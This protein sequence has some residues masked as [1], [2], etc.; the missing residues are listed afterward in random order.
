MNKTNLDIFNMYKSALPVL[1]D[2]IENGEK[3]YTGLCSIVRDRCRMKN[4]PLKDAIR[5]WPKSSNYVV[6]PVPSNT[7][8]SAEHRYD[9]F[10]LSGRSMTDPDSPYGLARL[11]L[12]KHLHKEFTEKMEWYHTQHILEHYTEENLQEIREAM[13]SLETT[14]E[15]HNGICSYYID[16]IERTNDDFCDSARHLGFFFVAWELFSGDMD[17]PVVDTE[18]GCSNNVDDSERSQHQFHNHILDDGV[19]L[20][21]RKK[22]VQHIILRCNLALDYV[23]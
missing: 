9:Q 6:Y 18:D 12:A 19:Q 4:T 13:I 22:L 10:L 1:E 16:F 23:G 11:D 15:Y 7:T 17:Y 2:V 21:L 8:D 3:I 20:E 5:Q 14:G